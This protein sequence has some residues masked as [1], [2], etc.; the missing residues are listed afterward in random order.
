MTCIR[1]SFPST[2]MCGVLTAVL[3]GFGHNA[4][5]QRGRTWDCWLFEVAGFSHREYRLDEHTAHHEAPNLA[6]DPD[7]TFMLPYV[8]LGPPRKAPFRRRVCSLI[9]FHVLASLVSLL[10]LRKRIFLPNQRGHSA[11]VTPLLQLFLLLLSGCFF[12]GR[13]NTDTASVGFAFGYVAQLKAIVY[14]FFLWICMWLSGSLYFMTITNVTHH[15]KNNWMAIPHASRDWGA[16]QMA[17]ASDIEIPFGLRGIPFC[18]MFYIFLHEQTLH[19]LFP[20]IDHSRLPRLRPLVSATA[21]NFGLSL[22]K[23]RNFVSLYLGLLETIAG[24]P[25]LKQ[26]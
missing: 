9:A 26:S 5:H 7:V 18:G 13:S 24:A 20:T 16:W 22:E 17:T 2:V 25:I 4:L 10:I 21:R 19:H 6:D 15:Q 1:H 23:P 3:G 14:A 12:A 8:E 11:I